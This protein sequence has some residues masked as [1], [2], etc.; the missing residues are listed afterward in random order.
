MFWFSYRKQFEQWE[1]QPAGTA[2]IR[3]VGEQRSVAAAVRDV[4][5]VRPGSVGE[6]EPA[7][8]RRGSRAAS[9]DR[10]PEQLP[11]HQLT[12]RAAAE[13]RSFSALICVLVLVCTLMMYPLS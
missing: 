9:T 5:V 10:Q 1:E 4:R 3:A 6:H 13:V 11:A 12:T 2:S 8:S 7:A